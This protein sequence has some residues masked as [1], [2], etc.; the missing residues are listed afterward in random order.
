MSG[1]LFA[2]PTTI[3]NSLFAE[4]SR[5]ST[6]LARDI[7][8]SL[9]LVTMLGL[10]AAAL[11]MV[12]GDKLLLVFGQQYSQEGIKLLWLLS[13]SVL[14]LSLNIIYL[15]VARVRKSLGEVVAVTSAIVV[16]TL[17]LSYILLPSLGILAPGAGWLAGQ[18]LVALAILPRFV[19]ILRTTSPVGVGK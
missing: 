3:S 5:Q 7:K 17:G 1:L 9:K 13:P 14:P 12:A 8:R 6:N 11:L 18:S 15:A 16:S 19:K 4:G 2:I 10:P